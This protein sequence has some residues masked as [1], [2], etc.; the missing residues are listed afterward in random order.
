LTV[1]L[2]CYSNR[3]GGTEEPQPIAQQLMNSGNTIVTVAYAQTSE[4]LPALGPISSPGYNYTNLDANLIGE[5]LDAF[6]QSMK[7]N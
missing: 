2:L 1:A 7:I 6:C 3:G 5:L 4:G